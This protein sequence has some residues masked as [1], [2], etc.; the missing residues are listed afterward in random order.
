MRMFTGRAIG[1]VA[2]LGLWLGWAGPVTGQS[3]SECA[4]QVSVTVR[5]D[6]P[7]IA[8]LWPVLDSAIGYT[9]SRKSADGSAWGETVALPPDAGGYTD[10][11]VV[12]GR[13]YEYDVFRIATNCTSHSYVYAG[14]QVPLIESRGTVILV[15]DRSVAP[16]L[17]VELALLEQ[18]LVGDGW[19]VR[20]HDVPRMS[21][22]PADLDPSVWTTRSNEVA[23]VRNLIRAD[24][25][26]APTDV[27]AVFLLGHV[28]VPYAGNIAPDQHPD[29]RGAWPADL[30]YGDMS[31]TWTDSSVNTTSAADP[32]NR[33]V[34]GDGKFDQSRAP[35][36][37]VL[38]VGRVDLA[39]LTAFPFGEVEALRRYLEK[40]HA[41]RHTLIRPRSR[42]LINDN[43]GA[44]NG[45][46]PAAGGWANLA[47][48]F[49][50]ANVSAGRWLTDATRNDFLWSYGC[51]YGTYIGAS[52]VAD[53][54]HFLVYDIRIV[55][56]M[57][58]GSYFGDWDTDNNFLRAPLAGAAY[59]LTTAWTGR[60][61]WYFHHMA[62]GE[63]IGFSTRLSQNNNGLYEPSSV[64]NGFYIGRVDPKENRMGVHIS[65]MGDP[66]LRLHPVA[67][68][69]SL[70]ALTNVAGGI[71]LSWQPAL[72][73]VLGYHVYRASSL[74]GPY[75]R[76]N[77]ALVTSN[78]FT[79]PEITS[80]AFYM[81]RAVK[82]ETSASGSYFNASQ[83]AF[84]TV[85][86]TAETETNT[87]SGQETG[88][89]T[90]NDATGTAGGQPGWDWRFVEGALNVKASASNQFT[91]RIVST[92]S[93]HTPGP[94]D[95]F[96]PNQAYTWSLLTASD[97]ITGF[98]PVKINL[99]TSEFQGDL[100]GGVL[101]LTL[102]E[103][104]H[105]IE[106]VF[107]P[108]H[109][110][111]A[112]PAWYNREWDQP[113]RIPIAD[114]LERFTSDA[115]GDARALLQV[116]SSTNGTAISTDGNVLVF[117]AKNNLTETVNY[118]VQDVRPYR[119]GDTVRVA[120]ST[121]T[122][123]PLP[124]GLHF[125]AYHAIEIE[126]EGEPGKL[127][128]LQSRLETE[129]Q[130]TN[131]GDP[132]VGTGEKARLFERTTNGTKFYR[133]IL[134]Q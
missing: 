87:W 12:V 23:T 95:H 24:Y 66:T 110:P 17:E 36:P 35:A 78:S 118:W 28:P 53:T 38:Q 40:D 106:L 68:P 2:A 114:L 69:S 52:G 121:L 127:Y 98:D 83:G 130:W 8:L 134:A 116:G 91:V 80:D 73:D 22:H 20:R 67:P 128:Q 82:L 129:S 58:F 61:D 71:D 64:M 132:I 30:Y 89:W 4:V 6:P 7:Q 3:I 57:L 50:P 14:I 26:A 29:H 75:A 100:G 51:G 65:L 109:P 21:V 101:S 54:L 115:D 9:V 16:S 108:N 131:Q 120:R 48:F 11:N 10:T 44:L 63:T 124:R 103:D 72:D 119:P 107:T 55:F 15:V 19:T 123:D 32:R 33:N 59:T 34:P 90:I 84:V 96:D 113:L 41:F 81:V 5:Q 46:L 56:T 77:R 45:E 94:P 105:S 27:K 112:Q 117:S 43:L 70:V 99:L 62:L 93:D 47:S 13:T 85:T 122:I 133:I 18:D 102:A 1:F 97:G 76:V 37:V 111:V 49:G 92:R 39:N 25:L 86:W 31:G 42:G 60:P 104:Q 79:E 88:V 74:G 126:W 125:N